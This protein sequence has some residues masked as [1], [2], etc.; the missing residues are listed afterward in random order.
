MSHVNALSF[1]LRIIHPATY[2]ATVIHKIHR[3]ER[4]CLDTTCGP[5]LLWPV[6]KHTMIVNYASS[7]FNKLEALLTDDARVVIYNR[8]VFIVQATGACQHRKFL[9]N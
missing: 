8:H 5:T 2:F 3:F 1:K 6:F 4:K 9:G 7:V